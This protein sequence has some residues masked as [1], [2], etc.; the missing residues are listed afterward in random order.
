MFNSLDAAGLLED[1]A[2]VDLFAGSGA[3]GIE[4]IS[5]GAARA[6]FVERDPA[7]LAALARNLDELDLADRTTVVRTDVLAWIPAMRQIDLAL[8]DPPYTF[9]AWT[10]LLDLLADPADVPVV[11][12][13]SDRQIEP[14]PAWSVRRAKRYGRTWVTVLERE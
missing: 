11:V 2:V 4:A 3:L 6:V 14:L 8:V 13:E 5:R 10:R 7:A 9:D 1:A 12:A